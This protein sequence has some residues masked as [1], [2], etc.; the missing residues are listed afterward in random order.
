MFRARDSRRLAAA[1]EF[2][3][4]KFMCVMNLQLERDGADGTR[5]RAAA[6]RGGERAHAAA[7]PRAPS[8]RARAASGMALASPEEFAQ[9]SAADLAALD[10]DDDDDDDGGGGGGGLAADR[11]ERRVRAVA[12]RRRLSPTPCGRSGAE[13]PRGAL[14]QLARRRP[15]RARLA[16]V[17]AHYHT[18]DAPA[19]AR[20]P[21]ARGRGRQSVRGRG[22]ASRR[23]R[24]RRRRRPRRLARPRKPARRHA[25]I[26]A[27]VAAERDERRR[28]RSV[29]PELHAV[30]APARGGL[31]AAEKSRSGAARDAFDP[32]APRRRAPSAAAVGP[33]TPDCMP[34]P[35]P[36]P[37]RPSGRAAASRSRRRRERERGLDPFDPSSVA[38]GAVGAPG[39]RARRGYLRRDGGESVRCPRRRRSPPRP[40]RR[41]RPVAKP[42]FGGGKSRSFTS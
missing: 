32:A 8:G 33:S 34:L 19:R 18:C 21:P 40:R 10:D 1:I 2:H 20:R 41:P 23:R 13:S 15:V 4:E 12:A 28:L 30:A 16:G 31:A 24:R 39:A 6:A 17:A 38:A 26:P 3:I 25:R 5:P 27:A 11:P 7:A 42:R 37:P 22:G 14:G 36:P 29:Q 9:Q 35:P